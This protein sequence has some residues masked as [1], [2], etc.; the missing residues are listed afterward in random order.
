MLNVSFVCWVMNVFVVITWL[1]QRVLTPDKHG[2]HFPVLERTLNFLML[3]FSIRVPLIISFKFL[4]LLKTV[5]RCSWNNSCR[6]LLVW[7]MFQF[8]RAP[9][10]GFGKN[11]YVNING[12]YFRSYC[13]R[14]FPCGGSSLASLSNFSNMFLVIT[15]LQKSLFQFPWVMFKIF[16]GWADSFYLKC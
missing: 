12:M 6:F 16:L 5:I 14:S 10:A 1:Q 7:R 8:L 11:Q 2:V 9:A 15:F 3:P 13:S 4:F